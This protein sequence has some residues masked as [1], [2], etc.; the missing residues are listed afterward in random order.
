MTGHEKR[1]HPR[2][3]FRTSIQYQ[4]LLA[5][6]GLSLPVTAPARDLSATGIAFYAAE[7]MEVQSHLK[8]IFTLEEETITFMGRVV[9]MEINE[10]GAF[11]FMI[12]VEIEGIDDLSRKRLT[13]F[14]DFIDIYSVLKGIDLK[15]VVDIHFVVGYPPIVKRV[16][17]LA[18]V[19][20]ERSF[21]EGALRGLL[22]NLL[23]DERHKKFLK[24]KEVNFIFFYQE[25]LRFRVNLHVQ[26]GK[27]EGVFRLIPATIHQPS[28]LGL[29]PVVEALLENKK[30]LILVAGRTGSGKTTTLSSMVEFLNNR[31]PGIIICI[32][33]P[34]EY[35]HTNQ[36]CIIK[37]REVG[38]D[39]LSFSSAA[40]NALRQSPDVMVIGEILDVE[41]MEVAISAAETGI[42]VLTTIHAPDSSQ[43][44]DRVISFFPPELHKHMQ[45]RLSL[46]LRG[47][48]TQ[49]LLP[50]LDGKGLVVASE[51]LVI[52]NAMKRIVRDADWKQIPSV[53]QTGGDAGMQSMHNSLETHYLKGVISGEYLKEYEF[54]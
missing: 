22:L 1:A 18:I 3:K 45:T 39:T 51:I 16:G 7:R 35:I 53:I 42:L 50:R 36:K 32:E 38:K 12:G 28:E 33:S 47:V 13:Q 40:K 30:G 14:L 26:Q 27:T 24:E 11:G 46:V 34:I 54:M 49:A 44:L 21:T 15:G 25:G 52:N 41:T 10:E 19:Q 29:P 43:A 17:K 4:K 2:F 20:G 23:D 6:G 9:R 37:Q 31:R 8:V 48:I 5:D